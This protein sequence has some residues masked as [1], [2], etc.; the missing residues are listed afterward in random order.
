MK[1]TTETNARAQ[2]RRGLSQLY[3][4]RYLQQIDKA[5]LVLVIENPLPRSLSWIEPYLRTDRNI[6]LVWDGNNRLYASDEVRRE[7]PFLG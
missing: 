1:S 4:Y 5:K 3:E 7:L 6:L 2:V